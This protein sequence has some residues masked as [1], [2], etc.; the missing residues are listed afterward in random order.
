MKKQNDPI[1]NRADERHEAETLKYLIGHEA[2]LLPSRRVC[3][4]CFLDR[5]YLYILI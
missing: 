4:V 1:G 5:L 3:T 2:D